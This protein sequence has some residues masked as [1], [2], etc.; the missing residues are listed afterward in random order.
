MRKL[1][2]RAQMLLPNFPKLSLSFCLWSMGT[3]VSQKSVSLKMQKIVHKWSLKVWEQ[4][5]GYL[6]WRVFYNQLRCLLIANLKDPLGKPSHFTMVLPVLLYF[7]TIWSVSNHGS[8]VSYCPLLQHLALWFGPKPAQEMAESAQ[9]AKHQV[10]PKIIWADQ[11][12]LLSLEKQEPTVHPEELWECGLAGGEG[13][14]ATGKGP[15]VGSCIPWR[16]GTRDWRE[17]HKAVKVGCPFPFPDKNMNFNNIL[18]AITEGM[19]SSI[20]A[21]NEKGMW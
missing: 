10:Y 12:T 14:G 20:T 9:G 21:Q 15:P 4:N 17:I 19:L 2:R 6:H 13:D 16:W 11:K 7:F 1:E 18:P 3:S 8:D 5:P